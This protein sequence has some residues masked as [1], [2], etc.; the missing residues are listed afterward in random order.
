MSS[1]NNEQD[2]KKTFFTV[3]DINHHKPTTQRRPMSSVQQ[4]PQDNFDFSEDKAP[5]YIKVT[6]HIFIIYVLLLS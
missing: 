1:N 6:H 2:K 3:V 4:A 5:R